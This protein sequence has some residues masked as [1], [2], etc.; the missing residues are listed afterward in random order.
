MLFQAGKCQRKLSHISDL[1]EMS[2]KNQVSAPQQLPFNTG[3]KR[4]AQEEAK[5][6]RM[7][8]SPFVPT[9]SPRT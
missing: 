2:A 7:T 5:V 3:E 1:L 8:Q 4:K 9:K 6:E